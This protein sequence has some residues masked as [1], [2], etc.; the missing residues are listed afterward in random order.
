MSSAAS[1]TSDDGGATLC[2][3]ATAIACPPV[4]YWCHE[5]DM[6]VTLLPSRSPLICPDCSRSDFLEEMELPQP[7]LHL[8]SSSPSS[9]A[10]FAPSP[11]S[12]PLALT[13]SDDNDDDGGDS[14][15]DFDNRH[16]PA[17]ARAAR[18]RRLIDQLVDGGG[19]DDPIPLLPSPGIPGPSPAPAA[20]IDALPTIFISD[21]DAGALP[22]CAVCKDEFILHSPARRLPCSHLYHSDCIVPWLSLH[23]S[24]PIC[25]SPL[26]SPDETSGGALGTGYPLRDLIDG[27]VDDD[28]ELAQALSAADDEALVLTAALWQVRRQ[29]RLSF[30]VRHPASAALNAALIQMAHGDVTLDDDGETHTSECPVEGDGAAMGGRRDAEDYTRHI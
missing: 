19:G 22:T 27:D 16:R 30:P 8:S 24:C 12:L 1:P 18:L 11:Q 14:V 17:S 23:N 7:S 3:S 15:S 26:P 29:H 4:M 10:A 21:A 6:G 13:D 25:R 20:S 2:S 5:C 9:S 28:D